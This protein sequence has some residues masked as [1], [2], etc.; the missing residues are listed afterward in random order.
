MSDKTPAGCLLGAFSVFFAILIWRLGVILGLI[1]SC[2]YWL[3]QGFSL[4]TG[5]RESTPTDIDVVM[6]VVLVVCTILK[7]T[8]R[9]I[10]VP[11]TKQ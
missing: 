1:S 3:Y 8:Q 11:D 2:A 6:L 10:K 4:A 7:I 5:G 9:N